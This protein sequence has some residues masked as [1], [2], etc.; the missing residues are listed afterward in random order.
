LEKVS[1][2]KDEQSL[3]LASSNRFNG[4]L[5]QSGTKEFIKSASKESMQQLLKDYSVANFKERELEVANE[6]I[7]R[8][9]TGKIELGN[10]SPAATALIGQL[11]DHIREPFKDLLDFKNTEALAVSLQEV[12]RA[13]KTDVVA[14]ASLAPNEAKSLLIVAGFLG[15]SI[16]EIVDFSI[17]LMENSGNHARVSGWFSNLMTRIVSVVVTVFVATIFVAALGLAVTGGNPWGGIIGA[18]VGGLYGLY[19]GVFQAYNDQCAIAMEPDN[20]D[21]VFMR[22]V[23][24]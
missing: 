7:L 19:Y 3:I 17:S 16:S 14:N 6:I 23:P 15:N 24:C 8:I 12:I 5:Q 10:I 9:Q 4:Y 11:A 21:E 13:F 22:W 18:A 2:S 20:W 1:L